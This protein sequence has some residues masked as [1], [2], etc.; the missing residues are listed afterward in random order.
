MIAEL[1]EQWLKDKYKVSPQHTNRASNAGSPCSRYLVYSRT[2]YQMRE[3]PSVHLLSIFTAG[4]DCENIVFKWLK[5]R[6]D[7][8]ILQPKDRDSFWP[9]LQLSGHLDALLEREIDGKKVW[10]PVE[11]KSCS[12][13]TFDSVHSFEEMKHSNKHWVRKYCGQMLLYLLLENKEVGFFCFYNKESGLLRDF[14]VRL[15]DHMDMA[16]EIL[17]RLEEVNRHVAAGTIPDRFYEPGPPSELCAT[18]DFQ[19][20][21]LPGSSYGEALKLMVEPSVE[22]LLRE[23]QELKT[24]I[25]LVANEEKRL[26]T[27]GDQLKAFFTG[28]SKVLIGNYI[29]T[30]SVVEKKAQEPTS[31]W[32][33]KVKVIGGGEG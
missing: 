9:A 29:V 5:D 30:G 7:L 26:K 25:K 20:I 14:E 19:T 6:L 32:L 10:C 4:N 15:C 31:Y 23:E 13:S 1:Q 16:E 12:I 2:S 11:I 8:P 18:C 21:C 22:K 27:V 17:R 3:A 28:K 33:R 24:A